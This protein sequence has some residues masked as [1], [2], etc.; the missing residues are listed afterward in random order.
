MKA[1]FTLVVI[2]LFWGC[3]ANDSKKFSDN[4]SHESADG[5]ESDTTRFIIDTIFSTENKLVKAT[6]GK[7][8]IATIKQPF[9]FVTVPEPSKEIIAYQ[10]E[11]T[12]E[13][14]AKLDLLLE[15]GIVKK[16]VKF[17]TEN[18]GVI[19]TMLQNSHCRYWPEKGRIISFKVEANTLIKNSV[20]DFR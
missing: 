15:G 16:N 11:L 12:L 4:E 2:C 5:I 18:L 1:S 14:F 6:S 7:D 8:S 20:T 13:G 10:I 3:T 9:S 17:A 19:T